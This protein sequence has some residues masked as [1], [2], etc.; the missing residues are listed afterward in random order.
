MLVEFEVRLQ[1]NDKKQE[2]QFRIDH[3]NED[4]TK[5]SNIQLYG[6]GW[7]YTH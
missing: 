6:G 1:A 5:M 3:W 2:V 7:I 4:D